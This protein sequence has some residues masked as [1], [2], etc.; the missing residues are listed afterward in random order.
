MLYFSYN[1]PCCRGSSCSRERAH[2][3]PRQAPMCLAGPLDRMRMGHAKIRQCQRRDADLR[4]RARHDGVRAMADQQ[5]ADRT[6][7]HLAKAIQ[8]GRR[9]G[10]RRHMTESAQPSAAG[11][12]KTAPNFMVM[13]I[14]SSQPGVSQPSTWK[15]SSVATMTSTSPASRNRKRS[16]GQRLESRRVRNVPSLA[17]TMVLAANP[18]MALIGRPICPCTI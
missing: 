6:H 9:P 14:A 18:P 2:C 5:R 3:T 1:C 7:G 17:P 10:Q 11:L 16:A 13:V 12:A 4:H 15:A 8:P